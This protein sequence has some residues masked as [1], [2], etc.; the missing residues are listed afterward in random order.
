[1]KIT[2]I[3]GRQIQNFNNQLLNTGWQY[4]T[5][6]LNPGLAVVIL[7]TTISIFQAW[8]VFITE[9]LHKTLAR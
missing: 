2:V 5:V 4:N 3:K 8:I 1:M 6:P 7:W 9:F